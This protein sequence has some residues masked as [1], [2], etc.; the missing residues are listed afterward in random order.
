MFVKNRQKKCI[1]DKNVSKHTVYIN[2]IYSKPI[3]EERTF[4]DKF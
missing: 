3:I 4:F 1:V 2:N